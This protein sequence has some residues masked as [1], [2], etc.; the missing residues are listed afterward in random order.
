[1]ERHKTEQ[2][3]HLVPRHLDAHAIIMRVHVEPDYFYSGLY[4][5]LLETEP[6][7]KGVGLLRTALKNSLESLCAALFFIDTFRSLTSA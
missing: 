3:R 7:S 1:M 5:S 2:Q 4:R 6:D